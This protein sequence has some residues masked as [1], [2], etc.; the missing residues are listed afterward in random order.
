MRI[1]YMIASI[2]AMICLCLPPSTSPPL[3][4]ERTEKEIVEERMGYYLQFANELVP[5]YHLAAI[6]Q[7]ERNI[8]Q[9]RNDL[10]KADGPISIQFPVEHWFGVLNP[11]PIRHFSDH[12]C[13]FRR[14]WDGWQ[15]RRDCRSVRPNGCTDDDVFPFGHVRTR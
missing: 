9:V 2:C 12:H 3:P 10:P 11:D 7:Y 1:H 14:L 4:I 15:W 5:W 13:I 8:Q 6:D